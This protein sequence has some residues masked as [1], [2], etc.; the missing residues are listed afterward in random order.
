MET[1]RLVVGASDSFE[2]LFGVELRLQ[3]A[4][5]W[6]PDPTADP[7]SLLADL[8][9]RERHGADLVIGLLARSRPDDWAPETEP[10]DPALVG[11]DSDRI[12][13]SSAL[14]F[15]DLARNER[16]YQSFMRTLA[17]LL[18][19]TPVTDPSS[20]AWLRGSFMRDAPPNPGSRDQAAA[21]WLDAQ[22]RTR[23]ITTKH[24]RFRGEP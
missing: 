1:Q 6:T 19:A 24:R 16:Y 13:G 7:A 11:R 17:G 10:K 20:E 22:N 3:G 15:A 2:V 12:G 9:A 14:V 21:P 5:V 4:L 8:E 23:V 18:G